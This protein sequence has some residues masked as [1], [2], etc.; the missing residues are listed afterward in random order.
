MPVRPAVADASVLGSLIFREP[1]AEEARRLMRNAELFEPSVLPYELASVAR[2][3]ILRYGAEKDLILQALRYGLAMDMRLV[4][5]DQEAALQLALEK[6]VTLYDAAYVWV[7]R[8]C[9][10]PLLT[11]D[12]KLRKA[13]L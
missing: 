3:K 5:V 13:A 10:G 9:G 4:E 6:G 11:F 8:L 7:S 1:K 12:E 2:K